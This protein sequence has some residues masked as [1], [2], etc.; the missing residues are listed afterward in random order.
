[1]RSRAIFL[2]RDGVLNHPVIRE[3]KSYPPP[4]VRDLRVYEG[5]REPLQRLKDRGFVLVV[6]TNQPD[7]ARGTTPRETV[8]GIN[9]AIAG[10]I[11]AIDKFFVCF[12]DNGDKCDCRKPKPGMLL[13]AAAEF[14]LDLER[15][16]MIGDRRG[17]VEAGKAAGS[18]TIFVDR[19]YREAAPVDYDYKVFSTHEALK[20]IES[21]SQ[22]E[23]S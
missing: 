8:E 18:R 2:D 20:I 13:A 12:H 7:V 23:K 10:E 11:P 21:E 17:D 6:V 19:N 9:A 3:G 1:M 4:S 15:S 14:D 22:H 5:L 16:Y